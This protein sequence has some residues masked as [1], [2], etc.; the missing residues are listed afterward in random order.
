MQLLKKRHAPLASRTGAK[1]FAQLRWN[2]R[3]FT[4]HVVGQ[5]AQRDAVTEADMIIRLHRISTLRFPGGG[6]ELDEFQRI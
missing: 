2:T 6:G 5:F 1:A 4:I 3:L